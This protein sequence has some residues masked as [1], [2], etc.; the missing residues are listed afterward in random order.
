METAAD[1]YR[2]ALQCDQLAKFALS[3]ADRDVTLAAAVNWR[4]LA[5]SAE[6]AETTA[7]LEYDLVDQDWSQS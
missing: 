1:C 4:K 7:K 5:G 3:D 2:H 6:E